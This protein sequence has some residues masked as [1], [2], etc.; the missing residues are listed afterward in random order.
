M[1]HVKTNSSLFDDELKKPETNQ[2]YFTDVQ[3]YLNH[4]HTHNKPYQI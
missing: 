2:Q 1:K 4:T 3:S